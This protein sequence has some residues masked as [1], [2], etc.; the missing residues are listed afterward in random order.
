MRNEQMLIKL[1]KEEKALLHRI[2]EDLNMTAS[3]L[4]RQRTFKTVPKAPA[5]KRRK[6]ARKTISR[7]KLM[8]VNF[9]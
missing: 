9:R 6:S 2:A 7:A 1:S 5:R 3:E 4:I 8:R